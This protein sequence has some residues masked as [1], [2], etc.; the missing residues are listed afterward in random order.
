M[1]P[2]TGIFVK[3]LNSGQNESSAYGII[4]HL[5]PA[6]PLRGHMIV[7]FSFLLSATSC[8]Q[9]R[10]H[11]TEPEQLKIAQ[12]TALFISIAT[13]PTFP[14]PYSLALRRSSPLTTK[15][16]CSADPCR[17]MIDARGRILH[18][19]GHNFERAAALHRIRCT[20]IP[21]IVRSLAIPLEEIGAVGPRCS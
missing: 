11:R 1:S 8:V 16:P 12:R 14:L 10:F 4:L 6:I 15:D 17:H 7:I 2:S 18:S 13:A 5:Y 9:Q 3:V 21:F 19:G 20:I